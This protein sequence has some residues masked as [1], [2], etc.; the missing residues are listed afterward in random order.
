MSMKTWDGRFG[1]F[2]SPY[3]WSPN[4]APAAGD[5]LYISSG[6]SII[7]NDTYGSPDARSSIALVG[8][9][10][11]SAPQLVALNVTFT[12]VVIDNAPPT[13]TGPDDQR[14]A[15]YYAPRYGSVFVIGTVVND[16]GA[17]IAGRANNYLGIGN[18][19]VTIA[20]GST[21]INQGSLIATPQSALRIIASDSSTLE[22]DQGISAN[23]G[24]I[25][26]GA[27]LTG[28]GDVSASG[29]LG[30]GV[31][32]AVELQAAVDAGQTFHLSRGVLQVDQPFSFMGQVDT[33][34]QQGGGRVILEG[35]T[36]A[37]W[38]VNG[39]TVELFDAGGAT[40]DTLQFTKPQD[41]ALLQVYVAPDA[42]YGSAVSLSLGFGPPVNGSLL[43]YYTA[44]DYTAPAA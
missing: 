27:H 44:P 5:N 36:A 40:V 12:N 9:N 41:L 15:D 24:R 10:A 30:G 38:D 21:L 8:M 4:E 26:I 13:Y 23:G 32:G 11:D 35:I 1:L 19:D 39:N 42:T 14:P 33:S 28:R 16:G 18:L 43:P 3:D 34:L 20:P 31:T 17:I 25:T 2:Q 6:L 37:S 7:F 22:N 29:G